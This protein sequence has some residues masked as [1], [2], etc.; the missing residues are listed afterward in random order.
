M[1]IEEGNY[2]LDQIYNAGETGLNFKMLPSK[3]LA[4]RN[5]PD[6][7]GDKKNK[8]WLM[9]LMCANATGT[10]RLPLMVIDKSAKP[11]A[12]NKIPQ[13]QLPVFHTNQKSAWMSS[14]LFK[15]WFD[16]QFVPK[17]K[18]FVC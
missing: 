16:E 4:S 17:V 18:E 5:E 7:P 13:N 12:L 14:N 6:P 15:I 9:V 3:T 2:L 8:E 10:H 1:A 11:R